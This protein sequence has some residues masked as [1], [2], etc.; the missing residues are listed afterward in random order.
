MEL[1]IFA[2]QEPIVDEVGMVGF[3]ITTAR[4]SARY[5]SDVLHDVFAWLWLFRLSRWSGDRDPDVGCFFGW[6]A[7]SL[8]VSVRAGGVLAV[9]AAMKGAK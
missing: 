1:P 5:A 9:G 6:T 4:L 3:G 7:R 2:A 8:D